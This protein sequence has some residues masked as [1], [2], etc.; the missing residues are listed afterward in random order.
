MIN[1]LKPEVE[2]I[3]EVP[4]GSTHKKDLHDFSSSVIP[5]DLPI[6]ELLAETDFFKYPDTSSSELRAEI[7]K[8]HRV[9]ASHV[10]CGNGA[11][12]LIWLTGLAFMHKH[13]KVSALMPTFGE[14]ARIAQI[15]DAHFA[16]FELDERNGFEINL[17]ELQDWILRNGIAMFFWCNPNNPTGQCVRLAEIEKMI[18]SCPNCLF[19]VDVAYIDYTNQ[20]VPTDLW[21]RH[22]NIITIFSLTKAFGIAGV[23]SGYSIAHSNLSRGL[24]KVRPPWNVNALAQNLSCHLFRQRNKY[25]KV[26]TVYRR[27]AERMMQ[28]FKE[29][30]LEVVPSDTDYFMIK[31][32]DAADFRRHMMNKGFLVR[33]LASMG[34]ANFVRINV[35]D[36]TINEL[37]LHAARTYLC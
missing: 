31:L 23:R 16:P 35:C 2:K 24:E 15:M 17:A 6:S 19:V 12:E 8:H 37:F 30:G 13:S 21:I 11:S 9:D 18:V 27:E 34:C 29:M 32:K 28:Q 4:H 22:P 25:A 33:E 36:K 26:S 20:S 5:L 14:Y 7:A 1:F 10:I 3:K